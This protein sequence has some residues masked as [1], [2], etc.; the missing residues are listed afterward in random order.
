MLKRIIQKSSLKDN[1]A[2]SD[3]DYW[4]SQPKSKR[5]EALESLWK[6]EH[7]NSQRLQRVVRII[8]LSAR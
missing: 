5:I 7:G 4:L 1:S 6:H 3:L 2:N 8:Q